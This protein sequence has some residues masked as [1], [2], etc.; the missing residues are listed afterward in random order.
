MNN[1]QE[2]TTPQIRVL[3]QLLHPPHSLHQQ[4]PPFSAPGLD[5]SVSITHYIQVD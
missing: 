3:L 1:D 2:G 4:S 5:L